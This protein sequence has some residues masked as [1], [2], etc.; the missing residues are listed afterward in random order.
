MKNCKNSCL[1]CQGL[2]GHYDKLSCQS[3]FVRN[4]LIKYWRSTL[5]LKSVIP[6]KKHVCAL[7]GYVLLSHQREIK[8]KIV[9][10][11]CASNI[12]LTILEVIFRRINRYLLQKKKEFAKIRILVALKWETLARSQ[13]GFFSSQDITQ[14]S[15]H[16]FS[17][18]SK[19]LSKNPEN[20]R[21]IVHRRAF[22]PK[23]PSEE[24]DTSKCRYMLPV[25]DRLTFGGRKWES[26]LV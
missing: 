8:M 21:S 10:K 1:N 2:W 17:F 4:P 25:D 6:W 12:T 16:V 14:K 24:S 13:T 20:V 3:D 22:N 23:S 9:K 15:R 26:I 7:V 5:F 11:W 19:M 18:H